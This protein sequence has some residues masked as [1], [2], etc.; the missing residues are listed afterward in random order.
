MSDTLAGRL[1]SYQI[2]FVES[3]ASSIAD[4][5]SF[6]ANNPDYSAAWATLAAAS[7]CAASTYTGSFMVTKA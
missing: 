6:C 1:L 2:R 3:E 7:A 5:M 4:L